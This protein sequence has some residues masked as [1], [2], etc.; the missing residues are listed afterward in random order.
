MEWN[1]QELWG[2]LYNVSHTSNRDIRSRRKEW[3]KYRTIIMVENFPKLM[4]D[5]K[6]S[7]QEAQKT[8]KK[9]NTKKSTSGHILLKL[10]KTKEK[11]F[12]KARGGKN[13]LPIEEQE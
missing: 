2:P 7:T 3:K 9:I 12:K 8:P 6:T 4:T 11:I 5:A 1:I 10:E 13:S